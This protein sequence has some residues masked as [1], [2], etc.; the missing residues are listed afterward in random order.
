MLYHISLK[1]INGNV[2]YPRIPKQRL[3]G[4]I[5]QSNEFAFVTV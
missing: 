1:K 5:K 3:K 4:K 2:L